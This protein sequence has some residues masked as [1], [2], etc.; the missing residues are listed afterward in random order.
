MGMYLLF[1]EKLWYIMAGKISRIYAGV[2]LMPGKITVKAGWKRRT[3][4]QTFLK[5]RFL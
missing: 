1:L 5:G 2:L 4:L 3:G